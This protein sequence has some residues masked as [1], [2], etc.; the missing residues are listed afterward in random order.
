MKNKFILIALIL[1]L[2]A[3]CNSDDDSTSVYFTTGDYY[4]DYQEQTVYAKVSDANEI[5]WTLHI[6][7]DWITSTRTSGDSTKL[8]YLY[9]EA[10]EALEERE[11]YAIITFFENGITNYDT[12]TITQKA[13]ELQIYLP[14]HT[15]EVSSSGGLISYE[16]ASNMPYSLASKPE[17]LSL[18]DGAETRALDIEIKYLDVEANPLY[19][20]REGD[21][22]FNHDD[23]AT[24]A[25][26]LYV[27]QYGIGDI[28]SDSLS[29]VALY[30]STN[31]ANWTNKWNLSDP[32]EDWYGV[33]VGS[34][35]YSGLGNRVLS[36]KLANNNLVG[37]IPEDITNIAYLEEIML[38]GNSLSGE[39][40]SDIGTMIQL[41]TIYLYNNQLSGSIPESLGDSYKLSSLYLQNNQLSGSIPESLGN[42]TELTALGLDNNNLKGTLPAS[43]GY[44][45]KLYILTLYN[46]K[47]EGTIPSSYSDNEMMGSWNASVYICPQQEGFGFFNCEDLYNPFDK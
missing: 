29:L 44:L 4:V 26:T 10:N 2:V 45:E 8:F 11:T 21:I 30:N 33:T 34:I 32:M 15:L 36:L 9:I 13:E 3:A 5:P 24:V 23:D 25:D 22:I 19:G 28:S 37:E 20:I 42:I 31:G 18:V 17:W 43:I 38:N 41:K 7:D 35:G 1:G 27:M 40:P 14:E 6:E 12:L 39:I 16:I 47:L 46:N